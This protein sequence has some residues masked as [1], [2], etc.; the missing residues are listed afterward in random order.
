MCTCCMHL[1]ETKVL[2]ILLLLRLILLDSQKPVLLISSKAEHPVLLR[3]LTFHSNLFSSK[4]KIPLKSGTPPINQQEVDLSQVSTFSNVWL[5]WQD[6]VPNL[7][8][9]LPSEQE[10]CQ[11]SIR[12]LFKECLRDLFFAGCLGPVLFLRDC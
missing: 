7:Q 4:V 2:D 11:I 1:C 8:P 3:I 5:K 12:P 10:G 6:N 9:L